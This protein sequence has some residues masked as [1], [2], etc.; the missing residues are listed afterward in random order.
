V[1]ATASVVSGVGG[2]LGYYDGNDLIANFWD[3][4]TSGFATSLDAAPTELEGLSSQAMKTINPYAGVPGEGEWGIVPATQ[5]SAPL[6]N[7]SPPPSPLAKPDGTPLEETWGIGASV[8][9]GYPFLWWQTA[10]A[11]EQSPPGGGSFSAAP[12]ATITS[13]GTNLNVNLNKTRALRLTGSNLNLV[14]EARVGGKKATINFAKSNSG[15]LVISELPLLPSGKYTLTLL[16]PVGLVAGE[17]EVV[18][19][20]KIT[21]LRAIEASGQLNATVR[22]VVRKQNLT[23]AM[24]GTL[25]CWGVT[26]SSSASELALAKQKA[27]AACAYAKTRMPELDVVSSS[28]TG[29]GQPAR[30][31]AVKLRY[32]K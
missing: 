20:A 6:N 22:S 12:Q 1:R 25:R 21:R 4:D 13:S 18:I 30:N 8:N 16:T 29:T 17:V 5:F 11:V 27:E 19:T 14:R 28:R 7:A 2:F 24:A 10:S 3:V 26:T 15:I 32:L 23:Y 9:S 31:Q